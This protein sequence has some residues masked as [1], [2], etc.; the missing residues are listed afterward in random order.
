M[1]KKDSMKKEEEG[2][3]RVLFDLPKPE[4]SDTTTT[5]KLVEE[6]E[7]MLEVVDT[8]KWLR[9]YYS[10][11]PGLELTSEQIVEAID[12]AGEMHISGYKP[13]MLELEVPR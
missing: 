1:M 13:E 2:M 10:I 7:W 12:S 8:I 6:L 3:A 4:I 9:H 11:T 5:I